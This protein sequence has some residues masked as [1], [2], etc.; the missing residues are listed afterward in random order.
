MFRSLATAL[1]DP[2]LRLGIWDTLTYEFVQPD[3]SILPADPTDAKRV[4]V[5]V[6]GNAAPIAAF[7]ADAALA[8]ESRLLSSAADAAFV[9]IGDQRIA[10]DT[11]ALRAEVVSSTDDER[12]RI[13][14]DMHD[15]A[16][17]RLVMLR[18]Q[19][20]LASEKL[21]DQPDEQQVLNRL[22]HELDHAIEDVRNLARR[23]L[24]PF[25][26]R[27]GL[28]TAVR[29][30]TRPW[31]IPVRVDDRGLSRHDPDTELAVYNLCLDALQNAMNHGGIGVSAGVR[32]KDSGDGIWF[33]VDDDGVGFDPQTRQPGHGLMGMTDRAILAGGTI[34]VQASPAHGVTISGRI[35]DSSGHAVTP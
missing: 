28:G 19:V 16:Q 7:V 6:A 11:L 3:G 30:V 34:K 9:A 25:V 20:G 17:Q 32:I 21:D 15:S 5:P 12:Q 24:T 2:S 4:W 14:R 27:N 1:G 23:F 10:E 31:P 35:P 18:V 29:A 8:N 26:V 22:G 33:S 13:A